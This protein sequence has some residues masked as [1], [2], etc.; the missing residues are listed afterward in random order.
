MADDP[1]ADAIA[2]QSVRS[3]R[4]NRLQS[5][6]PLNLN[7]KELAKAAAAAA[8]AAAAAAKASAKASLKSKQI[9]VP[10]KKKE[11][12]KEKAKEKEKA[13][14]AK[15][16]AEAE[17]EAEAALR[18]RESEI[19]D[20]IKSSISSIETD[21]II[22]NHNDALFNSLLTDLMRSIKYDSVTSYSKDCYVV[23]CDLQTVLL[24]L[25]TIYPQLEQIIINNND[26]FNYYFTIIN[27]KRTREIYMYFRSIESVAYFTTR[28]KLLYEGLLNTKYPQF[29]FILRNLT[30]E[31]VIKNYA[32]L[33][34]NFKNTR[35]AIIRFVAYEFFDQIS[36]YS[37]SPTSSP[38]S[39]PLSI[40][41]LYG[42][43]SYYITMASI[44][45]NMKF[46]KYGYLTIV[47]DFFNSLLRDSNQSKIVLSTYISY[48]KIE[49]KPLYLYL[50][51][52]LTFNYI[53][54]YTRALQSPYIS[55]KLTGNIKDFIR[56]FINIKFGGLIIA[57][58]N[59]FNTK[60]RD[61]TNEREFKCWYP[62]SI[63]GGALYSVF[64]GDEYNDLDLKVY[65]GKCDDLKTRECYTYYLDLMKAIA[66]QIQ[67]RI[68]TGYKM[69]IKL[70][71]FPG[72]KI[73]IILT[74]TS[75][76]QSR[77]SFP[78]PLI[79]IDVN[80]KIYIND[81]CEFNE[82]FPLLDL[83]ID[84]TTDILIKDFFSE[85]VV[86]GPPSS[87][88]PSP[89]PQCKVYTGNF[90]L[91]DKMIPTPVPSRLQ[92]A[93]KDE[94]RRA[95]YNLFSEETQPLFLSFNYS[96]NSQDKNPEMNLYSSF[97]DYCT[98]PNRESLISNFNEIFNFLKE[99]TAKGIIDRPDKTTQNPVSLSQVPIEIKAMLTNSQGIVDI[100]NEDEEDILMDEDEKEEVILMNEDEEQTQIEEIN[101]D[102]FGSQ[103]LN[104]NI[105][106][107]TEAVVIAEKKATATAAKMDTSGG[108][109]PKKP[110]KKK[111]KAKPKSLV[112][113]MIDK[114]SN[115]KM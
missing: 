70:E 15:A 49:C 16:E 108:G 88:R 40:K 64:K 54:R 50:L 99:T 96:L 31:K 60:L 91:L 62:I 26:S 44:I 73:T 112:E 59:Y 69:D 83:V 107:V 110:K 95:Y 89:P 100:S 56:N 102:I 19:E 63:S 3:R 27:S 22:R 61:T 43:V 52:N 4:S 55:T 13:K 86:Y 10:S 29:K 38:L 72:I 1:M 104:Y 75:I 84:C 101:E 68:I 78:A 37:I 14:K 51:K 106:V 11:E 12:A 57:I 111:V 53:Y 41:S 74:G 113:M 66:I 105:D 30:T 81:S 97:M 28:F 48:Y 67:E 103:S 18:A 58:V 33:I 23:E 87:P 35:I 115:I 6:Q 85:Y 34:V 109:K 2:P 77:A 5:I 47:I 21:N 98:S 93:K 8:K 7:E 45:A 114:L 65:I 46:V 20:K 32:S 92:K 94:E 71:D 80:Y 9:L 90:H 39:L 25:K 36:H 82:T 42:W 76:R 24:Q 17:A 79:S